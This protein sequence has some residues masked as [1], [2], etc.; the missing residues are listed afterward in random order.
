V[1]THVIRLHLPF[2]LVCMLAPAIPEGA[3]AQLSS[4]DEERLQIL[5]DPEALKKKLEKDKIRAPFEFFRSQVAPFDVLPLVKPHH[6]STLTLEVRSNYEDYEGRLQSFPVMLAG[7][8]QEMIYSRE[9]RL[10]KEQRTRLGMQVMLPTVPKEKELNL[11][12]VQPGAIRYDELWQAAVRLLPPHQM[13]VVVLSKD[14]A[15]Q[16]AAW[17]RLASFVPSTSEREDTPSVELQRY[18]RLVLPLEADKPFLSPHPLTW[19]PISHVL[20]DGLPPDSLSVSHQRAML[21]WLHWGGQIV[22]MGGAGPTFSVFRDSF[23]APYLPA[24]PTGDNKQLNEADLRPLAQSYPPPVQAGG[25]AD[26][27]APQPRTAAEAYLM[28]G[29]PYRAPVPIRPPTNRP[30]FLTGLQPRP[31]AATIPLGEAS[32]HLL[33]VE[34]RV[35]RGRITMLTI[36]PNDPSLTAWPGLD[37]LIRR[38][39]LRRPE[40]ETRATGGSDGFPYQPT[41]QPLEGPD[42]TWYRITSRDAGAEAE[43]MR[44]RAAQETRSIPS[45]PR[46]FGPPQPPPTPSTSSSPSGD[47]EEAVLKYM[48]VAEW[49]DTTALP[50]LCRDLL[51]KASGISVPSSQFVLKVI[52]AYLLAVVP[53]NYLVCRLLLARREWAWVVVPLLALG[54]AIGVERV[55]AYDLGYDSACDEIDLLEVHGGY[56]RAH[57]SRFASLYSTGRGKYTISYPNDPTALALP[58]DIGRSITG[59]DVTTSVWQ[60]YPVPALQGFSV[61]PRSLSM[62]RAE[63]MVGLSGPIELEARETGSVLVNRSDLELRDAVLVDFADS[64]QRR[65]TYLGTVSPG[66]SVELK[67]AESRREPTA[68]AEGYDGPD[69]QAVLAELRQTWEKRPENLGELRLVA[70]VPRPVQGQSFEPALDRHRGMTAVLIHLRYGNPP[71]PDG[72]RFNLLAV[73]EAERVIAPPAGGFQEPAGGAIG[74]GR[75]GPPRRSRLPA[76]TRSPRVR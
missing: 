42:L 19:A 45:P 74:P 35:G 30:V 72:P 38:V 57:L 40:E 71:A 1:N 13:L 64:R 2:F 33:A 53:L 8:P 4:T 66:A 22:L 58:L 14:S 76:Q 29:H 52:L 18:Y 27:E 20:W 12:L 60:S 75:G 56:S 51:E 43:A 32:P 49:R 46:G 44:H 23:L 9:A 5:S 48:G 41:R 62:F 67:E 15:N 55:A 70:W 6:W 69:P 50:R 47:V 36:N 24:D 73:P 54:F 17:N 11:E 3:L 31:G 63:Q 61:Q 7:M 10:V 28:Y 34:G 65:E 16:F 59:E 37:T 68:A 25:G 21:D 26:Q 39:I